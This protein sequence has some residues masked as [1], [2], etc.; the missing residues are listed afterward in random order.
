MA[1]PYY[2]VVALLL[3]AE[4]TRFGE[5][6]PNPGFMVRITGKGLEYG[7]RGC[8]SSGAHFCPP[9]WCG[10]QVEESQAEVLPLPGLETLDISLR[11]LGAS[12]SSSWMTEAKDRTRSVFLPRVVHGPPILELLGYILKYRPQRPNWDWMKLDTDICIV[13]MTQA[14]VKN[15]KVWPNC[16]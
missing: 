7:K 11:N 14:I 16:S 2:M 6:T 3:L 10:H 15:S 1:R 9:K 12:D 13:H 4:F 8:D 5:G